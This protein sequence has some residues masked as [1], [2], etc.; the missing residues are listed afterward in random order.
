MAMTDIVVLGVFVFSGVRGW[1]QGLWRSLL[2][3]AALGISIV[4]AVLYYRKTHN[5]FVSFNISFF[6][7]FIL[8]ILGSTLLKVSRAEGGKETPFTSA[9][10][11]LGAAF[12]VIW[13]GGMAAIM[14]LLLGLMPFDFWSF[15]KIKAD[16]LR[17]KS[18][19]L[20][21]RAFKNYL[22]SLGKPPEKAFVME[23]SPEYEELIQDPRVQ[24]LVRDP[25]VLQLIQTK[26]Y[27]Q[28]MNNEKMKKIFSDP[29]LMRKFMEL[30]QKRMGAG[31]PLESPAAATG[32]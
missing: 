32:P 15:G 5:I 11:I 29:A 30:Q 1:L 23:T 4:T 16:V 8:T 12:S 13:V 9:D 18:F 25:E 7:P 10:R 14:I 24:E 6:L 31:L 3:P 26:N 19:A 22:P 17:S 2:R 21:A 28:L 27:L 20:V